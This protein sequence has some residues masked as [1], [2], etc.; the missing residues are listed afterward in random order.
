MRDESPAPF[1]REI[2][3]VAET[4]S[5]RQVNELL[6]MGYVLIDVAVVTHTWREG[7]HVQYRRSHEYVVGRT[8]TMP[9]LVA[10]LAGVREAHPGTMPAIEAAVGSN[11]EVA[12]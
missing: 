7:D 6:A 5:R 10:A 3:E 12:S 8:A 9:A 11:E 2:V 1:L 4:R